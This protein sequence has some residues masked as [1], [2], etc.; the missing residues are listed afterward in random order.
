MRK[1]I[2]Y[3]STIVHRLLVAAVQKQTQH[4]GVNEKPFLCQEQ[5]LLLLIV[6][7]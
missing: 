1:R 7:S 2:N 3:S 6:P 5:V 4:G